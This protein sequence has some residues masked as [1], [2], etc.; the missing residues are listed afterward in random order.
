MGRDLAAAS[1]LVAGVFD[2]ADRVLEPILG[3]TLT[4]YIFVDRQDPEAVKQAEEDL[5]QTAITQPAV[6][7]MD[8]AMCR[9]LGEYGFEPDMVMGHS[10]G[11][12][13]ALVA[14]GVLTF[15]EAP[16]G[17]GRARPRDEPGELRRQRGDGG[18]DGAGR[19]RRRSS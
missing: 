13:G 6:L 1:P 7:T 19:D 5:K 3:R 9:L 11:E 18:G 10:L 17:G 4:S 12:Y 8:T 15:A 16:R 14:A 2:E